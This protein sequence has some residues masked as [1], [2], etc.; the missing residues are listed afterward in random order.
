MSSTGVIVIGGGAS[1][2][3][4]AG[5]AAEMGARVL[6]LEKMPRLGLKLGLSGKGRGNLTNQGDIQTFIE[7]YAPDGRFLRNCFAQFFNQDLLDFFETLG[8]P[9]AVERG[10]RV[11]PISDRAS[12]PGFRSPSLRATGP[13][14][15]HQRT[16]G[17]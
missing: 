11:F 3:M 14:Q 15:D 10:G 1:G 4:A 6:L 5:R 8:V 9:L 13:G 2:L 17:G 7:S 12:G 16:P